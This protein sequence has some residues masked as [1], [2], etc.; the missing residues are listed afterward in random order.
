MSDKFMVSF[1]VV[2]LFTNIPLVECVNLAVDYISEGNPDLKLSKEELRS[3][4][5]VDTSENH[6]LFNKKLLFKS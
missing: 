5:F 1:D 3:L 4:F 6:F 2:S